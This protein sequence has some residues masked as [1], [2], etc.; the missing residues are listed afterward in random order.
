MTE[1]STDSGHELF[2][3]IARPEA[4]A[5]PILWRSA[6]EE[7]PLAAVVLFEK[8]TATILGMESLS[9]EFLAVWSSPGAQLRARDLHLKGES[10][11][12]V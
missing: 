6:H 7:F 9:T 4:P 11:S 5:A 12:S 10:C 3:V 8:L 1:L 2:A